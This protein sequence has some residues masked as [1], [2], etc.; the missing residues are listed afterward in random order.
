MKFNTGARAAEYGRKGG[1]A[2]TQKMKHHIEGENLRMAEI[3]KRL[4]VSI[5]TARIRLSRDKNRDAPVTWAS[6]SERERV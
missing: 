2:L 1:A 6:L 3:A 4:G 5:G